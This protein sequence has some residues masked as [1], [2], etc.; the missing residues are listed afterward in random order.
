MFP[1]PCGDRLA[2]AVENGADPATVVPDAF[3][4]VRGG[5]SPL[6]PP[7]QL[8]SGAAGPTREAA[9]AAVPYGQIRVSTAGAIRQN[10]GIVVW[11]PEATRYQTVNRQHV[12]VTE[13]APTTFSALRPNPVPRAKRIDGDK[14]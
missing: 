8:F 6:P 14:K 1:D 12:N 4:V 11:E 2:E 3:V 9:A 13:A 10:G 5:G 7:G